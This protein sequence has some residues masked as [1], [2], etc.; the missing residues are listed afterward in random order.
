M[1]ELKN[2]LKSIRKEYGEGSIVQLGSD[3][4]ADIPV[5]PTGSFEIDDALGVG[6]FALG[7]IVEIFGP[8]SSGKSTIAEHAVAQ[9]QK[10]GLNTAY[11]DVEHALDPTYATA[12]GVD[13]ESM[14]FSQPDSGEE[15]LEICDRLC[16]TG[17]LG[18]I[19]VDSVAALVPQA[20]LNGEM[21]DSHIGLQARLMSQAL[22]KLKGVANRT[23]TCIIFINQLREKVGVMFGSPEVTPGGRALKFYAS[24]RLDVR[25]KTQVK[26]GTT[27]VGNDVLVKVV[28]NKVAPPF[29]TAE[30]IINY[31]EGIDIYDSLLTAAEERG[32]MITKGSNWYT[33]DGERIANSKPNARQYLREHPEVFDEITELV[34]NA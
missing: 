16:Q 25:R 26:D 27:V 11:I 10:M 33:L 31:G 4:L 6:G 2:A 13:I 7:K 23:G 8:E 3:A 15:A 34:R 20:E 9:A 21:G 29:R 5:I 12:I 14:L 28:K 1:S 32:Q 24:Q 18:L 22:R 19:V 17:E 30:I